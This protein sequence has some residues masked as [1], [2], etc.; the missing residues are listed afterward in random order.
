MI[1]T[2][3]NQYGAGAIEI[4]RRAAA[5]LGYR[6]IDQELPVVVAKRLHTSPDAVSASEDTSRNLGERLISGLELATP[7]ISLASREQQ[8]FDR[9]CLREVQVAVR[10]FASQGNVFIIGR[11]AYA[12]LG[13][14]DDVVRVFMYAPREWRIERIS[15][16][17]QVPQAQAAAEVERIDRARRAYVHDYYQLEWADSKHYDLCIDTARFGQQASASIIAGAVRGCA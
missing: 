16:A 14:R 7:E 11:A 17:M 6:V 13:R 12:I 2:V 1:V 5:Q 8:S 9:D 10:E 4:A 3:S 15:D